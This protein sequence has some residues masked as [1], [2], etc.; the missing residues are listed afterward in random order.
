VVKVAL[1]WWSPKDALHLFHYTATSQHL[2]I[3]PTLITCRQRLCGIAGAEDKVNI[4]Y[5]IDE[6]FGHTF[7]STGPTSVL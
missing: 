6:I 3:V 4:C 2:E 1:G 5:G 7:S